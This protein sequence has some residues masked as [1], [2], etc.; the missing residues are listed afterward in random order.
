MR[1]HGAEWLG[2]RSRADLNRYHAVGLWGPGG[3][4]IDLHWRPAASIA[5]LRHAEGVRERAVAAS[6]EGRPVAVASATDHLFILLCHAF[7]DDLERRNEWV[8]D[9]DLLFRLVPPEEWDWRLFHRL[10][11][12]H[13]L[14]RWARKALATVQT[15]TG[16]PPP[17]G[18]FKFR[19]AAPTWRGLLQNREIRLRGL[20]SSSSFD[21]KA[22]ANGRKARGFASHAI[23]RTLKPERAV[24]LALEGQPLTSPGTDRTGRF[25]FPDTI[26]FLEGRSFPEDGWR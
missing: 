14:D 3:T 11:Q 5:T 4:C 20:P 15:V 21:R 7:H 17:P 26:V 1:R 6:L 9:V 22:R 25:A 19:G 12:A 2:R 13:E 24:A 18:V 8:A 10:V 23:D 16:R